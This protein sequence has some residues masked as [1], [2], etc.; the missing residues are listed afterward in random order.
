MENTHSVLITFSLGHTSL[1][2][3]R[4]EEKSEVSEEVTLWFSSEDDMVEDTVEAVGAEVG[5]DRSGS[6][7]SSSAAAA[8]Q[9]CCL[10]RCCCCCC[11]C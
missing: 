2:L 5:E 1:S 9:C 6:C 11:C 8:A 10:Y 4:S 3:S 7:T